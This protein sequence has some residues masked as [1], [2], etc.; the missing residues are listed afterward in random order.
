MYFQA[1]KKFNTDVDDVKRIF[2]NVMLSQFY[3]KNGL[4]DSTEGKVLPRNRLNNKPNN[5]ISVEESSIMFY[6]SAKKVEE[7]ISYNNNTKK[8]EWQAGKDQVL[9]DKVLKFMGIY[10]GT[11]TRRALL[12]INYDSSYTIND[13][14][15]GM[16]AMFDLFDQNRDGVLT[17]DE[18]IAI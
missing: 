13:L 14:A 4:R 11:N 12:G 5:S 3:S 7:I 9:L 2:Q 8:W 15:D 10:V 18:F 17:R 6:S 1:K 16:G